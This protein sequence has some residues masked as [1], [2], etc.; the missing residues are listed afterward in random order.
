ME[1]V[2]IEHLKTVTELSRSRS[3]KKPKIITQ[4]P[5]TKVYTELKSR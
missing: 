5:K 1:S 2:A 3:I 4:Q